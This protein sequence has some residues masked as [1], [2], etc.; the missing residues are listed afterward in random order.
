MSLFEAIGKNDVKQVKSLLERKDTDVNETDTE[1]DKTCL[2]A[3][4]ETGNIELLKL[5]A[6]NKFDFALANTAG[7]CEA[8]DATSLK[9]QEWEDRGMNVTREIVESEDELSNPNSENYKDFLQNMFGDSDSDSG[10][11]S[12]SDTDTKNVDKKVDVAPATGCFANMN[13]IDKKDEVKDSEKNGKDSRN[14]KNKIEIKNNELKDN[15]STEDDNDDDDG[16][17]IKRKASILKYTPFLKLC[18]NGN[19]EFLDYLMNTICGKI[20]N[21]PKIDVYCVAGNEKESRLDGLFLSIINNHVEMVEYLLKNV[22]FINSSADLKMLSNVKLDRYIKYACFYGNC[23]IIRKLIDVKLKASMKSK[24]E[25][26]YT[27]CLLKYMQYGISSKTNKDENDECFEIIQEFIGDAEMPY[28]AWCA[29]LY[30]GKDI[31][32]ILEISESDGSIFGGDNKENT[33]VTAKQLFGDDEDESS[34]ESSRAP[35]L[36]D[37]FGGDDTDD[38]DDSDSSSD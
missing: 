33:V 28:D 32:Q 36:K 6:R 14:G 16:S 27:R 2:L 21:C 24:F 17:E 7:E 22:Y 1:T 29:L 19:V 10:S 4:A 12:G 34:E 20:E 9:V 8:S 5:L 38:S 11:D 23:K 15:A 18:E 35:N 31:E 37:M 25:M 30:R 26:P 3:I 13:E